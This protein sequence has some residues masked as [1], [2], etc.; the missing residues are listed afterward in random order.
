MAKRRFWSDEE[1]VRAWAR[2][3]CLDEVAKELGMAKLSIQLRANRL[4]KAGVLLPKFVR[5]H[6]ID[7]DGLNAVLREMGKVAESL[8]P[9]KRRSK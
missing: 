9:R 1:F 5:R 2:A 7:V 3:D 8:K 6:L 4:R